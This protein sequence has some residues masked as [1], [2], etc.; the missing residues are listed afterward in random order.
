MNTTLA[1]AGAAVIA[2]YAVCA[3]VQTFVSMPQTGITQGAQPIISFNA[4]RRQ[5]ARVRRARTLAL[6]ATVV[7]GAAAA[8]VVALAAHPIAAAFL[9]SPDDIAFTVDALRIIA[10]GF[11]FAGVSPLISAYFQALGSPAPS[12]LISVGT[13]LLLKVPLVLLLGALGPVGIWIA[14]PAGEA[15]AA[16]AAIAVLW[17]RTAV[18]AGRRR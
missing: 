18:E 4:G 10:T 1:V 11:V 9:T 6:S 16:T 12:Y 8:G 7:Y 17:W 13:L 3:R 5:F 2:A 14:L 15:L